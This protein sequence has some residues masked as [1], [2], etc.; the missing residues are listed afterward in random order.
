MKNDKIYFSNLD[1]IRFIAAAMVFLGHGLRNAYIYL[2]IQNN[3]IGKFLNLIS[4]AGT[5]VSIF[6]VLSGFLITYLLISEFELNARIS[7]KKFYIRRILR[8]WPLYFA[9]VIFSFFLYPFLKDIVKVVPLP[10]S[11]FTST[12]AL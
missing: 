5:G 12:S 8:I 10:I 7:I 6:F 4:K 1:A 3:F 9:V 11:D 2:P